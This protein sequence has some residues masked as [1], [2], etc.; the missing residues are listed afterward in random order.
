MSVS[1]LRILG[2]EPTPLGLLCLRRRALLSR[3]GT[4][5]TEITLDHE[6]LMSSYLTESE[7][8]LA[9]YALEMCPRSDLEVLVGG[10]GLGYTAH[11]VCAAAG[12]RVLRVEVVEYLPQVIAWLEQ[13]LM[14]LASQ[15]QADDRVAVVE[16]DVFARLAAPPDRRYDIILIDIDHSPTEHLGRDNASFYTE[17]GLARARRHLTEDGVLGV[18]S[19]ARHTPFSTALRQAFPRV[20]IEPI[21]VWNDLV[22]QEQTDWLFFASR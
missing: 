1:N 6:L 17:A 9:R 5:V 15:L 8:A 19:Y 16:G 2:C 20:R 3:P 7:R 22:D 21:T 12:D 18:W 13:G 10:L 14:P 4:I 11:E